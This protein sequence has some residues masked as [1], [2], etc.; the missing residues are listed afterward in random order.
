[1]LGWL[2][3][4]AARASRQKRRRAVSSGAIDDIVFSATVR[5]EPLVARRVDDAHAALAELADDRVV[6]D[7]RGQ[8]GLVGHRKL[9][10]SPHLRASVLCI[11]MNPARRMST[12]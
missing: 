5:C 7:S 12:T 9:I 11:L 4:A 2:T 3:L 1:M 8:G 6:P 10:V